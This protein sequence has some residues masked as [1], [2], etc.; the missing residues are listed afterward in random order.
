MSEDVQAHIRT[1]M[2]V[3]ISLLVLTVVTVAVSYLPFGVPLAVTVAL[4][5]AIFKGSLVASF[6]MHLIEE[7]KVIFAV[8]MLT[9]FFFF[10]MLFIPLMGNADK[11]GEFFTLPNADAPAADEGAH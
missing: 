5:I 4:I 6:F 7:K 11:L 1:Y 9:V 8:L 2:K 10:V 3:G